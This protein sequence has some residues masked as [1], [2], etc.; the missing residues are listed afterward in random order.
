[1]PTGKLTNRALKLTPIVIRA[2]RLKWQRLRGSMH[3][4]NKPEKDS[5]FII[6]MIVDFIKMATAL[7]LG[8]YGLW[9]FLN[10]A[11]KMIERIK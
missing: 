8:T 2:P 11:A 7:T 5:R 6:D 1:M 3:R 9:L 10:E 4:L